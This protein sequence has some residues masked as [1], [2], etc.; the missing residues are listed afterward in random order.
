VL[1]CATIGSVVDQ[2]RRRGISRLRIRPQLRRLQPIDEVVG[3]QIARP[4]I[5]F[6]ITPPQRHNLRHRTGRRVPAIRA[7]Q[8]DAGPALVPV[9]P[10]T[11]RSGYGHH[12]AGQDP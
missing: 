7:I 6:G 11:G 1:A 4:H 12:G 10:R 8:I 2:E 3:E 5:P 9:H